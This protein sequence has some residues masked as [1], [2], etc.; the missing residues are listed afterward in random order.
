[1]ELEKDASRKQLK[2]STC[3]VT[4][5]KA[6]LEKRKTVVTTAVTLKLRTLMKAKQEAPPKKGVHFFE[7]FCSCL[8]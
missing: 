5:A 6:E 7:L 4:S 3:P 8:H 2:K 1:M